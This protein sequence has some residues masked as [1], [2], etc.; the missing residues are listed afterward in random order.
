M[1]SSLSK[2]LKDTEDAKVAEEGSTEVTNDSTESS[3]EETESTTETG[4]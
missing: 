3:V 2:L 1:L 4:N